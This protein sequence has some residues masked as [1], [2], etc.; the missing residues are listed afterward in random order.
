MV[1]SYYTAKKKG[2]ENT[3]FYLNY[4]T[5][6]GEPSRLYRTPAEIGRDIINIKDKVDRTAE[7]L[8]IRGL[9][10]EMVAECAKGDPE[11]WAKSLKL[12]VDETEGTLEV[13]RGMK[14]SFDS[15]ISELEQTRCALGI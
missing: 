7:M 8:N 13:I 14:R 5:Y 6:E 4:S 9:L 1:Y 15:L 3:V 2:V 12:L 10:T 11:H